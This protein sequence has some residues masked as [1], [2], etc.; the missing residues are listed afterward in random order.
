MFGGPSELNTVRERRVERAPLLSGRSSRHGAELMIL[1]APRMLPCLRARKT[2]A[3][4]A[5][6]G[7]SEHEHCASGNDWL[8]ARR[9]G[10]VAT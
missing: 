10:P 8:C 1:V 9:L 7:A 5:R 3:L 6:S 4:S 2:A